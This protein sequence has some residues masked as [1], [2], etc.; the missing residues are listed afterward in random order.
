MFRDK[1]ATSRLKKY[2]QFGHIFTLNKKKNVT[3]TWLK[4]Y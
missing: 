2:P 4:N 1:S 3:D